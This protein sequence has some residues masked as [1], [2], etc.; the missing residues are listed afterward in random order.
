MEQITQRSGQGASEIVGLPPGPLQD[1]RPE[2]WVTAPELV[3][4]L[5]LSQWAARLCSLVR[6]RSLVPQTGQGS[7]PIYSDCSIFMTALVMRI[8]RLSL[9]QITRWLRQYPSLALALG[10][11]NGRTISK[12]HL[13]RRLR[14]L[15]PIPFALY[16]IFLVR[17]L[18]EKGIIKGRDL[19]IDSTT[20]LA[21]YKEDLEAAYSF[22]KKFGYKV[23]TILCRDAMLPLYFIVSS[24]NRNDSPFAVPLLERVVALYRLSVEVVRA[25][26]AYFVKELLDLIERLG[27]R[28]AVDY[29]VRR[30]NKSLVLRTWM[31]FWDKRM[32]K[33]STI[34]RFF[35]IA[36]RWFGLNDF[37]AK[38]HR[39]FLMHTLL[40]YCAILSVAL[41]AVEV[42]QPDLRLSPRRLLAPC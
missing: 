4:L 24:A 22:A 12:S 17:T 28:T 14:T 19:V 8:W 1:R 36:K 10:Y 26:A 6:A 3:S 7:A 2:Q 11:A 9:G 27:A 41:L 23:H 35:G 39:A 31:L 30:K 34:E 42:G 5:H 16:M 15:G 25:D 29:N 40:T 20:V 13:S 18:I 33:R 32:G 38:G 37:H 21:W